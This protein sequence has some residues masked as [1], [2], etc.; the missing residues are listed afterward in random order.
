[1][2]RVVPADAEVGTMPLFELRVDLED[3]P[4]TSAWV[5]LF[6]ASPIIKAGDRSMMESEPA[7]VGSVVT[8]KVSQ[9]SLPHA[10]R[11]IRRRIEWANE[12][13]SSDLHL[14]HGVDQPWSPQEA[15]QLPSHQRAAQLPSHQR[16]VDQRETDAVK[17][18]L[19]RHRKHSEIRR[20]ASRQGLR[21][22][23]LQ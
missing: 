21:P 9:P 10:E 23:L 14:H 1:M 17:W 8:W 22:N 12:R 13:F 18:F 4:T 3:G 2:E 6:R 19:D 20:D 15:A 16:T 11:L 5:D 7:L